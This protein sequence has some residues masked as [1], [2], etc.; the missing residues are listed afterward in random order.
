MDEITL[1]NERLEDLQSRL[2]F[3]ED[4][5]Q[6]MS[7]QMS[8]Q[9]TEIETHK[10]IIAALGAKVKELNQQLEGFGDFAPGD[11]RPPHY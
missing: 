1:L 7:H 5:L 2:A 8:L 6:T 9:A 11:E 3:Q 4:A 10:K